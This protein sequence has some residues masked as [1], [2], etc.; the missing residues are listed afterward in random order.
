MVDAEDI[1]TLKRTEAETEARLEGIAATAYEKDT[2]LSFVERN[3]IEYHLLQL[4]IL[5]GQ[6]HNKTVRREKMNA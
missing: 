1:E 2:E 4:E 3:F 5:Q 6:Y